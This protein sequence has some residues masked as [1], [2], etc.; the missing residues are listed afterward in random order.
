VAGVCMS[1]GG[2]VSGGYIYRYSP[3]RYAAGAVVRV[4]RWLVFVCQAV[5]WF[6]EGIYTDIAPVSL[7]RW[8]CCQSSEVA[9]VC[10]SGGGQ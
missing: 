2:L 7:R 5:D 3:R 9:G 10:M 8:C 6:W 1:G 4:Q